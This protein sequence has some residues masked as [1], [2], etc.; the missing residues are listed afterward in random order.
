[1]KQHVAEALVAVQQGYEMDGKIEHV[2]AEVAG[3]CAREAGELFPL[4]KELLADDESRSLGSQAG[5]QFNLVFESADDNS[6]GSATELIDEA[7]LVLS[8]L[9]AAAGA[10]EA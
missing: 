1:M 4:L 2:L 7:R 8:T 10:Q 3:Q 5:A 6:S 9:P